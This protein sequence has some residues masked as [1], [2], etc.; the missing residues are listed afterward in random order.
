MDTLTHALSGALAA[1]ATAPKSPRADQLPLGARTWVGFLAAAF[2]DSD[3][4][5]RLIDPVS[6]LTVY[7]RGVTHSLFLLPLWAILLALIFFALTRGRFPWRAFIGVSALSIAVHILGDVITAF[8]TMI[9]APLSYVRVAVPT[10]F[11]IDPYF[12]AIIAA[13][14][15]ASFAARRPQL[16]AR[17]GA[18]TLGVYVGMQAVLHEKAID[19]GEAYAADKSLRGAVVRAI[20]QPLS[21]FHWMVVVE[22]KDIYYRAYASLIRGRPVAAPAGAGF[23]RQLWASYQPAD[24]APWMATPR[25][26]DTVARSL[27]RDAW[28]AEAL[29][30]YRRFALFPVLFRIDSGGAETC[31]WFEDLRFAIKGRPIPFRYGTCRNAA[32]DPWRLERL[33]APDHPELLDGVFESEPRGK[34]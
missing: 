10:T 22:H 4:L 19:I 7:H 17:L 28:Q 31:V 33:L 3:F 20:P 2:P 21:P 13:A 6:Y 24:T 14:L 25:Y 16:P 23:W 9:F 26:G 12:T 32:N 30:G 29:A 1:R 27:A 5:V 15:F 34:R 8:G 18:A 11:I